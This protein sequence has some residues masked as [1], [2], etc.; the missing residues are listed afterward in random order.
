MIF[1]ETVLKKLM[2][3]A[4]RSGGLLAGNRDGEIILAGPWWAV[5]IDEE[6]ISNKTKAAL[7]EL[8]GVLPEQG[9]LY[10][11]TDSGNQFEVPSTA[12][13]WL[14]D[15]RT[16]DYSQPLKRTDVLIDRTLE[17]LIRLFQSQ[18]ETI[19]VKEVI[20]DLLDG[21]PGENEDSYIQGPCR[22]SGDSAVLFWRTRECTLAALRHEMI[23]KD[24]EVSGKYT[25]AEKLYQK[26]QRLE[27]TS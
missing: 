22:R 6:Y 27:L 26:L 14:T 3:A 24:H 10:R 13:R 11:C 18:E 9:D 20:V 1:N 21:S 4:Y 8:I 12:V 15:A 16:A 25:N 5:G 23:Q 17:G 7:V 2:K 19:A